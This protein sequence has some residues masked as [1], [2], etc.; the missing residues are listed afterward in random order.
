MTR[1]ISKLEISLKIGSPSDIYLMDVFRSGE[2]VKGSMA[3]PYWGGAYSLGLRI[4]KQEI[5]ND[6]RTYWFEGDDENL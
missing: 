6:T 3:A 1:V 2:L 5:H 4:I